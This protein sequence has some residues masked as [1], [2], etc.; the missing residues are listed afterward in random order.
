LCRLAERW[1]LSSGKSVEQTE[2]DLKA[3]LPQ[4]LWRDVHLQ[5]IYFGREVR[6]EAD[7]L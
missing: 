5:I 6:L 1:G 2:A 3:L 4:E 7:T